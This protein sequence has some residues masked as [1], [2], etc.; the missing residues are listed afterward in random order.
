MDSE[1]EKLKE[2]KCKGLEAGRVFL[3]KEVKRRLSW[4]QVGV[5]ELLSLKGIEGREKEVQREAPL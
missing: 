3:D 1:R 4:H 2:K 5:S